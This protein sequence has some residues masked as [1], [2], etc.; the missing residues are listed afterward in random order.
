MTPEQFCYWLQGYVEI[1]G[2]E[3]T[4]EQWQIIKDHLQTVFNKVTPN[5]NLIGDDP[6]TISPSIRPLETTPNGTG[7]PPWIDATHPEIIC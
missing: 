3:P 7:T 5:R 2:Q 1:T 6:I 4:I